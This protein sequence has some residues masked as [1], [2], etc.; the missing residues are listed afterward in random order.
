MGLANLAALDSL[1][2]KQSRVVASNAL[3]ASFQIQNGQFAKHA[4]PADTYTTNC[5]V[6]T[7]LEVV[8]RRWH[9]MMNA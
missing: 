1:L 9:W 3:S 4:I 7:A 8:M 6:R 2:T 5:L